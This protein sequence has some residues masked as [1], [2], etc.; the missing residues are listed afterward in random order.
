M[1]EPLQDK[2]SQADSGSPVALSP[3]QKKLT[4][5]LVG[6]MQNYKNLAVGDS[7][8]IYF[9][10][11]ELYNLLLCNLP[12][13]LGL[14]LRKLCLPAFFKHCDKGIIPGK[15]ITIRQAS[16]INVG[17]HFVLDDYSAI[18]VRAEDNSEAAIDIGDN[19]FLGKFSTLISKGGVLRLAS[20]C[21]IGSYCRVGT[22]SSLEIG[23]SVLIAAFC[24]IGAANHRF[25]DLS[26]PIIE[27][28]MDA[29]GGIK[30]GAN[31]W[32]GSHV[33]VLDGV[34]IG[35][36]VVIGAHSFVKDDIPD[37]AIA[38]G[39]PAKVIRLRH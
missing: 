2:E 25:A 14:S 16:R 4:R 39:S 1:K 13:V 30:I 24:Y 22:N 28:E 9:I 10:N 12:G 38:V 27:Q 31:S 35:Q 29:G 7:S 20:G 17:K 37:R 3:Q 34:T 33:T 32:I 5:G 36:D 8:W 11:Y 18:E 21:N 26:T 23:E 19:V 15:N 6:Q